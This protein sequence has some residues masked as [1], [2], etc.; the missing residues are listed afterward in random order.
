MRLFT[1][2]QKDSITGE[3]IQFSDGAA[4][5]RRPEHVGVYKSIDAVLDVLSEESLVW[6]EGASMHLCYE[7]INRAMR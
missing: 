4:I 2:T 5:L 6:V 1:V 3:G 7:C